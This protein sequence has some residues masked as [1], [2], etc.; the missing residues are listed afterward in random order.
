MAADTVQELLFGPAAISIHDD[1]DMTGK[2]SLIDLFH[3]LQILLKS[4]IRGVS[5]KNSQV[6]YLFKVTILDTDFQSMIHGE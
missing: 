1:C 3:D 5:E 4:K 6:N 2:F